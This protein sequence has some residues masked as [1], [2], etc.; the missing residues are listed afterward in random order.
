MFT[1]TKKRLTSLQNTVSAQTREISK[2]KSNASKTNNCILGIGI[3]AF[4]A[5]A[6]TIINDYSIRKL[7]GRV[8]KCEEELRNHG[9][10]LG[11]TAFPQQPQG[12]P[13]NP[14]PQD[15][16]NPNP[17]G[18]PTGQPTGQGTDSQGK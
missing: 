8:A 3:G 15:P 16:Q 2:L 5:G 12:Q 9:N 6:M 13:Q 10:V 11:G 18:Q 4:V 7:D 17:E 1:S 14:N